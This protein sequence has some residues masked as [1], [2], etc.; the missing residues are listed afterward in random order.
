MPIVKV[1]KSEVRGKPGWSLSLRLCK[2][3]LARKGGP[4]VPH[5]EKKKKKKETRRLQ[6]QNPD[7]VGRGGIV[8]QRSLMT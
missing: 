5:A 7:G 4:L 1:R 6:G 8:L 3:G 2:E